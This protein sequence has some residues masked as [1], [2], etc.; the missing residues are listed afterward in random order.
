[1]KVTVWGINYAPELTG[2]GP[3]NQAL[4]EHLQRAGHNVNMVTTFP[5]YPAWQ[6]VAANRGKLFRSDIIANVRVHRC[7]H[8][9]PKKVSSVKRILHEASFVGTSFLRLLTL[10]TPDVY[11]VVS[12]PLLLGLAA[13]L[14]TRFR[15]APFIFHVQDLQPDA[16][17][18]LGMLKPGAFSR[19]LYWLEGVAYRKAAG[20]SG[21][22]HG[23]LEA[24]SRKRVE[25]ERQIY[26]PNPVL[27]SAVTDFPKSG[28]FRVRNGFKPEDFLAVYSGNLGVKQGLTILIDVAR[29]LQNSPLPVK[30]IICGD[31]ASRPQIEA[32][33]QQQNL[34]CIRLFPL[35]AIEYYR[36]LL[37]DTDVAL[38]TQQTGSGAAFFPSKLLAALAF[39]RPI[40]GVADDSSE[41]SRAIKARQFGEC[42]RPGE[43]R[44]LAETLCDLATDRKKLLDYGMAGRRYAEQFESDKVLSEFA[45]ELSRMA[46]IPHKTQGQS[47]RE[48]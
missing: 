26:F 28:A 18:N 17:V 10:P 25:R 44:R 8:Y 3:Y 36:E 32:A 37:V 35:Q 40:V 13:W 48:S 30:I 29:E 9:V 38:I 46:K 19:M 5:Y 31:G 1:M 41:L 45:S 27:L 6:K 2:I 24:F 15:C 20:I 16:A 43:A 39:G 22:S 47:L 42:V 21:I 4:C 11:I 33:I 12:P 23:M 34:S 14:V 7:W